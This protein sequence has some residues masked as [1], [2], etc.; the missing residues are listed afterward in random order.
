MPLNIFKGLA[1][2]PVRRAIQLL[3][4]KVSDISRNV[5]SPAFFDQYPG[6]CL[7]YI[8]SKTYQFG[9][10]DPEDSFTD[11]TSFLLPTNGNILTGRDASFYWCETNAFLFVQSN[12]APQANA[13]LFSTAQ[14]GGGAIGLNNTQGPE[15]TVNQSLLDS[16]FAC[17]E[18]DLYDKKRGRSITNGFIP[19]QTFFAG[20]TGYRRWRQATRWDPDSE[21]EPRVRITQ[22]HTAFKEG[23]TTNTRFFLNLSVKGFLSMQ[24][25]AGRETMLAGEDDGR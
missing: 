8:Y 14:N 3:R 13:G 11:T 9:E 20:S 6:K 21:I 23:V 2:L 1:E 25:V 7:P 16:T 5:E 22:A 19:G 24:E 15:A 4:N 12:V 17:F 10:V 18:I